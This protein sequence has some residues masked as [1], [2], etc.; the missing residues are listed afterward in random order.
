MSTG[1]TTIG[2]S[3]PCD[4]WIVSV[5]LSSQDLF[6]PALKRTLGEAIRENELSYG[7][8][9]LEIR[10]SVCAEN[11]FQIFEIV[12]S[13]RRAGYEIQIDNFGS[14]NGALSVLSSITVDGLKLD[15]SAIFEMDQDEKASRLVDLI[16]ETAG[17]LK[18]PVIAVGVE[19]ESQ[20]RLLK[21]KGCAFAQGHYFSRPLPVQEF[22]ARFLSRS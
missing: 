4:L 12:E 5:N 14:E 9:K 3:L 7:D 8:L 11:K 1:I 6:D 19:T 16:L 17:Y 22:E 10:E 13:L 20:L 18:L 2:Y 15:R 21:K